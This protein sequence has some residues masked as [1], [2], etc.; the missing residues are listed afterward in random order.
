M[1]LAISRIVS[2]RVSISQYRPANAGR[3]YEFDN[4]NKLRITDFEPH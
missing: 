1:I 3:F 2:G 4:S